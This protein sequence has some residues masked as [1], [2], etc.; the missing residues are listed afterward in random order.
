MSSIEGKMYM[1][2]IGCNN[3]LRPLNF[4]SVLYAIDLQALKCGKHYSI[5]NYFKNITTRF[6]CL[7]Q[8]SVS[9]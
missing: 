3:F 4:I 6:F 9:S 8:Q 2:T 1:P 5:G 7:I